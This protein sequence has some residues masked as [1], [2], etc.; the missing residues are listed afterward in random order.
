MRLYD[1]PANQK[2]RTGAEGYTLD[3]DAIVMMNKTV[4]SLSAPHSVLFSSGDSLHLSDSEYEK[5]L[6]AWKAS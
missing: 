3:L 5:M 6:S 1:L 2:L 4:E